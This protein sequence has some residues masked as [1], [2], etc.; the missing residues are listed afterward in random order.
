MTDT[1]SASL[2]CHDVYESVIRAV[3]RALKCGIIAVVIE[4][5]VLR[6][7]GSKANVSYYRT[8]HPQ[9]MGEAVE[10]RKATP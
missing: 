2:P 5:N 8:Q 4:A 3:S 1:F 10:T 7:Y 6:L 9:G